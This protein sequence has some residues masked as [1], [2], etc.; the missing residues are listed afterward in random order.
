MAS[1]WAPGQ[2]ARPCRSARPHTSLGTDRYRPSGL[3]PAVELRLGEKC[4]GCL[5]D[6][7]GASQLFDL[8][9]QR[10]DAFTF[11]AGNAF[12][13][14]PASVSARLTPVEQGSAAHSRFSVQWTRRPPTTT[15]TR[16]D[17]PAPDEL[18]AREPRVRTCWSFSW[19]HLLECWSLHQTW[20][21]SYRP[22]SLN[23]FEKS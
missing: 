3:Q 8:A 7:M 13:V 6:V 5:E 23:L 20:S 15:D 1:A 12:P 2:P 19:L 16:L 22:D 17:A 21:G 18:R 4:A 10:L 9:L 11:S 14:S